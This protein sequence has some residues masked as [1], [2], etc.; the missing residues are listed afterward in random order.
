M[1]MLTTGSSVD[2]DSVGASRITG[3]PARHYLPDFQRGCELVQSYEAQFCES[4]PLTSI[5]IVTFNRLEMTRRCVESVAAHTPE[6]H[7]LIFVDN[8]STDGTVDYLRHRFSPDLVIAN[9]TNEGFVRAANRGMKAA[10]GEHI[11]LLNNDTLVTPGWLTALQQPFANSASTGIVGGKIVGPDGRVQLAG[12]YMA[13]DGSAR[14]IGEGLDPDDPCLSEGREV[15]YVGGHCFLIRR[16]VIDAIG[17]LD[18]DYGFGYHE[19]TDYCYRARSAGFRVVYT[20]DC[21][22]YHELHG[23]PL[24]DRRKI[25]AEN[26][27]HFLSK[28]QDRLFLWRSVKHRV[29]FRSDQRELPVGAGW[30]AAEKEFTCTGKDAW[31]CLQP[32]SDG[33]G[34]L[35]IVALAAHPDLAETPLRLE[36]YAA[37]RLVGIAFFGTPWEWRQ[38][39]FPIPDCDGK[40]IRI[41][42]KMDRVWKPNALL[43][44]GADPREIG[45]AVQRM[46]IGSISDA[47]EWAAEGVPAEASIERLSQHLDYVQ[48][49]FADRE[50]FYLR[51]LE[52]KEK[53]I[54][55]LQSNLERYHATPPFRAYFAIKKLI[56]RT[57]HQGDPS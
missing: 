37:G 8:G 45:L 35:E 19:D 25:I 26:R 16:E 29:E 30:F 43:R 5:V 4:N 55:Q 18:E 42:L 9:N 32:P 50:A 47:R 31:C 39:F 28:W 40:P 3:F 46:G 11:L 22:V 36:V 54:S 14:M 20:P 33:L 38:L 15:C 57:G 13:F 7:E 52:G 27:R 41:D 10:R 24:P 17:F 51:E 53:L 34:V 1:A 6:P 23:T 2:R 44:D 12:A 49:I 21:V 48:K 56:G